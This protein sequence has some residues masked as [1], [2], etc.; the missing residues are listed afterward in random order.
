MADFA[1]DVGI[2][3]REALRFDGSDPRFTGELLHGPLDPG[4][5]AFGG[6]HWLEEYNA[7]GRLKTC[8]T[9]FRRPRP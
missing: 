5:G 8:S 3:G 2:L 4:G 6:D 1:L 9:C 7:I